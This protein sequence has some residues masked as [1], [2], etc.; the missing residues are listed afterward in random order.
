MSGF[1]LKYILNILYLAPPKVAIN[2]EADMD[3]Y[4]DFHTDLPL[5]GKDHFIKTGRVIKGFPEYEFNGCRFIYRSSKSSKFI[6]LGFSSIP[7]EGEPQ[8][9]KFLNAFES[10]NVNF[11][12]CLDRNVPHP[13]FNGS[14]YLYPGCGRQYLIVMYKIF[15]LLFPDHRKE[16]CLL[17]GSSK[18]GSS[19]LIFGL[20]FGFKK[21]LIAAPQIRIAKYLKNRDLKILN[22]IIGSEHP[23]TLDDLIIKLFSSVEKLA[24]LSL[25]VFIGECDGYHLSDL[26]YLTQRIPGIKIKTVLTPGG[27]GGMSA[28]IYQNSL[29]NYLEKCIDSDC[30]DDLPIKDFLIV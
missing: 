12:I 2:I 4:H 15:I 8:K 25:C 11:F 27:H 22:E 28:N 29:I 13:N 7:E 17:I 26:E 1:S 20:F 23:D 3:R 5:N 10:K 9:Y 19:A 21:Y 14:Y 30:L 16:N 18:G 6:I 24:D